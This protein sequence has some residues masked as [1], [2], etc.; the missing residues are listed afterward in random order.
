MWDIKSIQNLD[1]E[2]QEKEKTGRPRYKWR[3]RNII[4]MDLKE[5]DYDGV[6]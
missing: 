6:E 1:Q 2:L 4:K 3:V 5:T